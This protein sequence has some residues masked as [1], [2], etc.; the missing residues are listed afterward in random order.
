MPNG[1][2]MVRNAKK[3]AACWRTT[4]MYKPITCAAQV[5]S[6]C[7]EQLYV[8]LL[9]LPQ[10]VQG[11]LDVGVQELEACQE[12]LLSA[13][14]GAGDAG[15]VARLCGLLGLKVVRPAVRKVANKAA[16]VAAYQSL[17]DNVSRGY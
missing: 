14:W 2:V 8:L 15:A 7:A 17:I 11:A 3:A 9:A 16:G 10:D 6:H 12:L 5:R 1:A 4:D 13:A